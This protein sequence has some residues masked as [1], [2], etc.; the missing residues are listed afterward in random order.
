MNTYPNKEFTC[1]VAGGD[2]T[3]VWVVEECIKKGIDL[4]KLPIG[5]VP[6]GTGND[7]SRTMGWG[8]AAKDSFGK[9]KEFMDLIWN[10]YLNDRVA[11]V[12]PFDI[13]EIE[14]IANNETGMFEKV[15]NKI[16][17]KITEDEEQKVDN[18]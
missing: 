15:K 7:F 9:K 11:D 17:T 1:I 14:I 18:K 13:W 4:Q 16:I 2:G 8:S 12:K 10:E 5:I 6:L 3:I